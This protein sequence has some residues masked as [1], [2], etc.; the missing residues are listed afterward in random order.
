MKTAQWVAMVLIGGGIAILAAYWVVAVVGALFVADD[1][2]V[3][4]RI[5]VTAVVAGA[6]VLLAVVI[7]QRIRERREENL[8]EIEY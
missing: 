5:A 6:A 8:K 2:P 4:I 3:L 7:V 1:V